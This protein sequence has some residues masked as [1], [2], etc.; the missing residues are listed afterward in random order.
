MPRAFLI[1][2]STIAKRIKD[3]VEIK[4]KGAILIDDIDNKRLIEELN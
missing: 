3:V 1:I 4:K 2:P